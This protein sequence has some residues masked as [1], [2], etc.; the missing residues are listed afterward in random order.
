[1]KPWTHHK[2][3]EDIFISWFFVFAAV[4][5]DFDKFFWLHNEIQI[6]LYSGSK[7]DQPKNQTVK[8]AA[9]TGLSSQ[10]LN[11]LFDSC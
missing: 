5:S 1:M 8:P 10:I 3:Q 7:D 11:Q 9:K 4:G 6:S 2:I